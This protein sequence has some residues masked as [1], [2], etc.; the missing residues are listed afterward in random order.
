[1]FILDGLNE[2][3]AQSLLQVVL[4]DDQYLVGSSRSDGAV[5]RILHN[6]LDVGNVLTLKRFCDVEGIPPCQCHTFL[7][8]LFGDI[9]GD[10]LLRGRAEQYLLGKAAGTNQRRVNLILVVGCRN[11]HHTLDPL[12]A[13]APAR[14]GEKLA[15]EVDAGI[16]R[17]DK[18]RSAS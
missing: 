8:E 15:R 14:S 4:G 11:S 17:Q 6:A 7:F 16:R 9:A 5:E 13:E 10:Q 18:P 12:R 1:M 2:N 3:L